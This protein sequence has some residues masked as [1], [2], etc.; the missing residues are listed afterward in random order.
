M[1]IYANG[2][3][4]TE[5]VQRLLHKCVGKDLWIKCRTNFGWGHDWYYIKVLSE[6]SSRFFLVSWCEVGYTDTDPKHKDFVHT[7]N[8]KIRDYAEVY[9]SA[10]L[11]ELVYG[12]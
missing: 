6:M 5:D 2:W 3:M 8:I 7:D 11:A 12:D 4:S 9:T 10:E 1:K